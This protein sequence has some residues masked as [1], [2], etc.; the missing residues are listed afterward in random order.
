MKKWLLEC[1]LIGEKYVGDGQVSGS[2]EVMKR[3][4]ALYKAYRS[5]LE[6]VYSR[7]A[8][9][10]G[11]AQE[12]LVGQVVGGVMAAFETHDNLGLMQSLWDEMQAGIRI[13][14]QNQ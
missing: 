2:A 7:I 14:I 13:L 8:S 9:A 3:L 12:D 5:A 6:I 11:V 1:I 4:Q 10:E